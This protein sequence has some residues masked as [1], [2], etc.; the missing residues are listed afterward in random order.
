LACVRRRGPMLP[1][2]LPL[3]T[4]RNGRNNKQH[5]DNAT[6]FS[7]YELPAFQWH[8]DSRDIVKA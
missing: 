4:S 6:K 3:P 7:V 8:Q 5:R 2:T 1:S